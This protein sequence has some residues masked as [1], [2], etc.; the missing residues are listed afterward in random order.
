MR[1]PWRIPYP[2]IKD[3][4]SAPQVIRDPPVAVRTRIRTPRARNA[5][6]RSFKTQ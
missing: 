3:E 2:R 6:A 5:C 4:P 1:E